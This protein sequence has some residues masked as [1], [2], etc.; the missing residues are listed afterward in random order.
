MDEAF[1]VLVVGSGAGGLAAAAT[2]AQMGARV[3]VL[4]KG[5]RI[6]GTSATSGG[7]IWIPRSR[8]A[9]AAGIADGADAVETY[10]RSVAGDGF[11]VARARRFIDAAPDALAFFER[12][13]DLRYALMPGS[14][15]YHSERPGACPGGRSLAAEPFDGRRLGAS[16]ELV[17]RPLENALIAGGTSVCT[18]LDVPRLLMAGKR[19]RDAVYAAGLVAR[20][21][22]DRLAG[23]S[24]GTRMTNG[25]A[26]VGR[27]LLSL[28][29]T[30]VEIRL[31][32]EVTG[33]HMVGGRVD[34]VDVS[35][36][37][38]MARLR[39]KR[40]VILAAGGFSH[41]DV[42]KTQLF[43]H[44]ARGQDHESLPPATNTGDSI[45]IAKRVGAGDPAS[46]K[47]PAAWAP[48]SRVPTAEGRTAP[49]PHFGDKGKPGVIAVD[50]QGR[51]FVNEADSYHAFVAA[52]LAASNASYAPA[53]WLIADHR[54]LRAYGLGAVRPYPWR[55]QPHLRSG[56]LQQG[57][58][59]AELASRIGI[60][61][62]A[63]GR[64]I[65]DFNRHAADGRDPQFGR[66]ESLF[67][68]RSGDP[69][70]TPNPALAPLDKAPFYALRV[71]PADIGTFAGLPTDEHARVLGTSGAPVDGLYAVGNDAATLFGGD[72]PAAGITL[73]PALTFGYV[74]SRHA[75]GAGWPANDDWG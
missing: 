65:A 34:G 68:R 74:A 31:G 8:Q 55:L 75:L 25:N 12:H 56:Y 4:E 17:R 18:R 19:P 22:R 35:T 21:W 6:G 16:F 66:G 14:P 27:L 37:G 24:R 43:L 47:Q 39:A 51:R 67:N 26:L 5:D 60:D 9:I 53:A 36:G 30:G 41:S 20:S 46:M 54:A 48:V 45:R 50:W 23:Y 32:H 44:V 49:W 52:M 28:L 11:N 63:L 38:R 71:L 64:T 15:D 69:A 73:G 13:A 40:G 61:A 1:D 10:I 70:W 7:E 57:G 62:A 33:L 59:I 42:L 29:E 2:A 58:T 72:Y 3:L